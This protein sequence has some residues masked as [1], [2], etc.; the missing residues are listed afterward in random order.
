MMKY[1]LIISI[2]LAFSCIQSAFADSENDLLSKQIKFKEEEVKKLEAQEIAYRQAMSLNQAQSKTLESQIIK[3][4]S[5]IDYLN[6]SLKVTKAKISRTE[7]DIKFHSSEINKKT[8]KIKKRKS[9]MAESIGFLA[10]LENQSLAAVILRS[11]KLSDFFGWIRYLIDFETGL[12][13]NFKVLTR[14]KADL[15]GLLNGDKNLKSDLNKFKKDLLLKSLLVESQKQEKS[16]LLFETKDQEKEYQK[17]ISQLQIK[18]A[19][20]QKQIFELENKLRGEVTGAP[21]A[22]VGTLAW[23][24]V[25]KITQGYGPTTITGFYNDAYKFHNG[26]DIAAYYG[27]PITASLDGIVA[28]SGNDGDYAYGNWLAM[29]HD[30][31]LTTLYA[32]LLAKTV[33]IGDKV[34]QGQVLGYEGSSGFVTG[35]HLHF[36]VYSTNTF[37]VE[38]RWFGL[39]PLGGSINPFDYLLH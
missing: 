31:G 27:A 21:P 35:P 19:E 15:G 39:L 22:Q 7:S 6:S 24:L 8:A 5:Q 28:A 11:N 37:R 38:N 18:Q 10:R 9:T 25:G 14:E 23:P 29:R 17:I 3:I 2:I 26:I 34:T 36:T 12:Y 20:I 4:N 13:N 33:F 1:F 32:H 30:N 16:Q